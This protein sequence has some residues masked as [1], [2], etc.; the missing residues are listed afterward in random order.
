MLNDIA[1]FFFEVKRIQFLAIVSQVY[2]CKLGDSK[3]EL[4][5]RRGDIIYNCAAEICIYYERLRLSEG[6]L[7]RVE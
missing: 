7:I 6:V 3:K 2:L 5:V 1:I 4:Q